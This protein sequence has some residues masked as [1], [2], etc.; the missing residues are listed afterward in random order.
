MT[1]TNIITDS[2][3]IRAVLNMP[4]SL[5]DDLLPENLTPVALSGFK[6][7]SLPAGWSVNDQFTIGETYPVYEVDYELF[8]VGKDGHG[9]KMTPKAWTK[10]KPI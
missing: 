5:P 3:A 10:I 8:T 1:T 2:K 7:D 6:G 9:K 4:N